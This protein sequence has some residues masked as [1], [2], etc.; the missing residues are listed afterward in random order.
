MRQVDF[1][2]HR[3]RRFHR[4]GHGNGP[5]SDHHQIQPCVANDTPKGKGA[6]RFKELAEKYTDG[7]VKVEVYPNSQ[8]FKDKEEIEALQLGSVQIL[9]PSTAKFAPLGVKEFEALDLPWLF[10]DE[11]TYDKAMKDRLASGCSKSLSPR[12]QRPRLLDQWVPHDIGQPS[13][14]DAGRFPG[15][16]GPHLRIPRLLIGIF[17][18]IG[19]I[20]QIM[21]FSKSIRPCRPAWSTPAKIRPRNY[22]TQKF[23]EVQKDITVSYH[24]H[25]QYAVSSTRVLERIAARYPQTARQGDGRSH[26]LHQLDRSQGKRG[27]AAD[28]KNRAGP[29]CT[30]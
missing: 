4:S 19:S 14:I 21:A 8:L 23:Y 30:I 2:R 12:H 13:T 1:C 5:E 10:K 9:A 7:K 6:L 18:D 25:L 22:L 16:Q 20:P 15:A 3:G 24:A 28:I 26:R 27:C 11:A 17:R 29:H